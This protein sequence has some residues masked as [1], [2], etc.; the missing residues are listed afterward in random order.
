MIVKT[1]ALG[2]MF[3]GILI[4]TV[5]ELVPVS[6]FPDVVSVTDAVPLVDDG[7]R[8]YHVLLA[9][10]ETDRDP[11]PVLDAVTLWLPSVTLAVCVNPLFSALLAIFSVTL[12]PIVTL[13]DARVNVLVW[14]KIV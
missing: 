8:A 5:E 7:S 2:T 4:F 12:L 1:P 14:N 10:I 13:L 9:G 6:L 11:G 3:E